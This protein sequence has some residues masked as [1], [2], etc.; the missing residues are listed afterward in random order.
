MKPI[1]RISSI[2]VAIASLALIATYFVPI[3]RIDLWAPQYPE[4]LV[5][6]I[7]IF[8]LSGD[9]EIING[10]NHYIGMAHIKEEMFPEFG[11]LPYAVG[12]FIVFGLL[13]SF[14]RSRKMLVSY[15]VL[16]VL[17][18][19]VALYD[20]WS[21]GYEYGH[22]LSDDAPIKVPGMAYQPPLIGYKELLNFGAYSMPDLGG[23]IFVVL[24]VV[25]IA[26]IVYEF[27]FVKDSKRH[28]KKPNIKATVLWAIIGLGSVLQDAPWNPAPINYGKD[29]CEFCKMM[30]MDKKYAAEIVTDKGKAYK[31]DDLSCMVKYMKVNKLN[32]AN[33]SFFVVNDYS[34]P[35]ELIDVKT[36]TFLGSKD[37]RSP[38]RGDVAA[39]A[40]KSVAEAT[41]SRFSD[42]KILTW[43]EVFESF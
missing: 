40:D 12:F 25:V 16:I 17:A 15:L 5:M 37:L 13:T 22:N 18:G 41:K 39:F 11:I 3:W 6:K 4:G 20:F 14:L 30:I 43:K 36:A 2:G 33:F 38:M 8:K 29:A 21:W 9:V 24:G 28:M 27:Y 31:F 19:I 26:A 7:W 42:A 23:W 34:K 10:L 1:H 35:G 32:E